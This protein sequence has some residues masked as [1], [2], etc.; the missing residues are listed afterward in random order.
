[1]PFRHSSRACTSSAG[2]TED[3]RPSHESRRRLAAEA[4]RVE[5]I[6]R[7]P[8]DFAVDEID[9]EGFFQSGR[10]ALDSPAGVSSADTNIAAAGGWAEM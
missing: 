6:Y 7:Q 3:L 5:K 1:M 9:L 10:A 8:M 4:N 2:E